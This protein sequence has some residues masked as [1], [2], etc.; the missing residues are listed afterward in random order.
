MGQPGILGPIGRVV[1]D[2]M[3]RFKHFIFPVSLCTM[4]RI[5]DDKVYRSVVRRKVNNWVS[6]CYAVRREQLSKIRKNSDPTSSSSTI[7]SVNYFNHVYFK[8]FPFQGSRGPPGHSGDGGSK[9]E[10]VIFLL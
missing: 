2:S 1:S 7:R 6:H 10:L 9:G 3:P 4:K 8:Y 5:Y